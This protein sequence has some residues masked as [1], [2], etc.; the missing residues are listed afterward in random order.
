MLIE[1]KDTFKKIFDHR[2]SVSS[3][4]YKNIEFFEAVFITIEMGF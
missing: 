3:R 2:A 1:L 4:K